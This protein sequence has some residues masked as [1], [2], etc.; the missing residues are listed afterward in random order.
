MYEDKTNMISI[1]T[2]QSE[3]EAQLANI[4]WNKP[5]KGL[6][7]PIEYSIALGGKRIRPVMCLASCMLFTDNYQKAIPA[8]LA[9]EVFH[10][11]TLLHD[12][13]M[14]KADIRR[15]SPTVWK[16][17]NSNTAILSGDAMLIEAYKLL[18]QTD[19]PA[20][21]MILNTFNQTAVEV[22]EGQQYDM[23]FETRDDV[24][25]EE[26]MEMIRLKTAVLLA[27][28]VKIGALIGGASDTD[29]EALYNFAIKLGLAF[30]LQDD[31][32]DTYGDEKTFGKAIGGDIMEN[33]KTFLLISA[34]EN[35][36]PDQLNAIQA[37]INEENPVREEKVEAIRN[38][39]DEI[40]VKYMAEEKINELFAQALQIVREMN[41]SA[42]G[43]LFFTEFA[44]KLLKRNK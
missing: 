12:D 20:F 7:T 37:W 32:L 13:V 27:G 41:I 28:A 14:D 4:K 8:A 39:Y 2:L 31:L 23:E 9:I 1:E 15:N 34:M 42:E 18:A 17:W 35:A 36:Q 38:I 6:Y 43:K 44:N 10:N 26:Y 30:Q 11:F 33:K 3:I 25:I 22:C 24:S 40:G 16:K 19:S 29:T 5:P 21:S